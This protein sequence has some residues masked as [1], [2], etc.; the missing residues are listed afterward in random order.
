MLPLPIP[1]RFSL[2]PSVYLSVSLSPPSVCLSL[3]LSFAF[4]CVDGLGQHVV[5][6]E[7]PRCCLGK[8]QKFKFQE[9][10][11]LD[12]N[13]GD[14]SPFVSESGRIPACVTGALLLDGTQNWTAYSKGALTS[15]SYMVS[16]VA[17]FLVMN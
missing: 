8:I 14:V 4:I 10:R 11:Q 3:S 5:S 16:I 7:S 13:E 9:F 15:A 1:F 12:L 17:L 6:L 2:S